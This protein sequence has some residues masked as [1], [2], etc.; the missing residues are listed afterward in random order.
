MST[1]KHR[2]IPNE[3]AEAL[4]KGN[5]AASLRALC[6]E[7]DEEELHRVSDGISPIHTAYH[8]VIK[9]AL[10]RLRHKELSDRL[11]AL[12]EP[13]RIVKWTLIVAAL[14][15]IVCLL[16]WLFPRLPVESN[17]PPMSQQP[18]AAPPSMP[19]SASTVKPILLTGLVSRLT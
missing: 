10:N 8:D 5:A 4:R 13:H 12:Q 7:Y 15:F 3:V 18:V 2:D 14:T 1:P 11:D 17:K 16:A 6:R 19:S 9:E